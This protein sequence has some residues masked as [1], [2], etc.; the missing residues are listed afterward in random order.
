RPTWPVD[1]TTGYDACAVVTR[2][3][4][5]PRGEAPIAELYAEV[6]G[7]TPGDP[8]VD[9]REVVHT[10]KHAVMRDALA[11]DIGRV[12]ELFVAVSERHRRWRDFTRRDLRE[13]LEEA[14]ACFD[15]Y[16]TYVGPDG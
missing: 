10:A 15:V 16:R 6:I 12:T 9:L 5:D 14:A 11:A 8:E 4:H 13:A 3:L 7:C 2:L 1:G